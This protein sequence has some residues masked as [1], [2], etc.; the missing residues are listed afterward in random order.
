M[1][2]YDRRTTFDIMEHIFTNYVKIDDTLILKNRKEFGDAPDFLLPL[3]N[4]LKNQ[5]DC[6]KLAAYG[7]VPF[8]EADMVLQL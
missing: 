2:R 3:N 1:L 5:E 4:Y 6:Q 8:S 7:E